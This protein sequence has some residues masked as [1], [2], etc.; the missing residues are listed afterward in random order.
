M[1]RKWK[2]STSPC[3]RSIWTKYRQWNETILEAIIQFFENNH[4]VIIHKIQKIFYLFPPL[5][6]TASIF[7]SCKCNL[8][9]CVDSFLKFQ[10]QK[11][12][13]YIR[14]TKYFLIK[15]HLL[16]LSQKTVSLLLWTFFL[17][18]RTF[19]MRRVQKTVL[20]S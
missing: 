1:W 6:P 13:S 5:R 18:T 14:D 16:N 19:I 17:F 12:K 3:Y 8:S 4:T 15:L 11:C 20:K 2:F 10:A 7:N 9:K